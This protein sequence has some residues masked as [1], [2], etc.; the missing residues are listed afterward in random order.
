MAIALRQE[1]PA[2]V[3]ISE[4]D[5]FRYGWR[6]LRH[7][8]PDGA[9]EFE[10]VPLTLEDVLYPQ[11]ED[12]I[13]HTS[14]H[15]LA[16]DYLK[17]VIRAQVKDNPSAVVLS[18]N[19]IA[20]DRGGVK[21]MGPD[22]ALIFGVK[23]IRNWATFDCAEEG[24]RPVLVIEVTSP[25]IAHLDTDEKFELYAQAEI[26]WYFVVDYDMPRHKPPYARNWTPPPRTVF[27]YRL[28]D[29]GYEKL[30]PDERGWL[31]MEPAGLWIDIQDEHVQCYDEAGVP[32]GDYVDVTIAL[33]RSEEAREETAR[34]L[35]QERAAREETARNLTQERSAREEAWMALEQKERALAQEREARKDVEE[36]LAALEARLREMDEQ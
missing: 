9:V 21:P 5:P 31:W 32:I 36:R 25:N 10:Q 14:E 35:A 3:L 16:I 28:G 33:Q 27:G 6:Y 7:D 11:E 2:P 34:D 8:R 30:Q 4:E 23:A 26:P 20:W 19:R 1:I 12:F 22:I 18:D 15:D 24:T 29:L 17:G 13:V